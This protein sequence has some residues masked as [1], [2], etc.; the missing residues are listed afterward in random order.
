MRKVISKLLLLA[1]FAGICHAQAP[2]RPNAPP[3]RPQQQPQPGRPNVVPNAPTRQQAPITR[4]PNAP[5][6]AVPPNNRPQPNRPL[7]NPQQPQQGPV[8]PNTPTRS[9]SVPNRPPAQQP[10]AANAPRP[11][12]QPQP[13]PPQQSPGVNAPR[14]T[15]GP[16]PNQPNQP[17]QTTGAPRPPGP[18]GPTTQ[19]PITTTRRVIIPEHPENPD[20]DA[21]MFPTAPTIAPTPEVIFV[22]TPRFPNNVPIHPNIPI[23]PWNPRNEGR[24]DN[25]CPLNQNANNPIHLPHE[26]DCNRFY[27]CDHGLIFE[28]RC[29]NGQHW[30][31]R[32]N[33]CDFPN[34]ANC[35]P[36]S[37]NINNN[38]PVV[39]PS[40]QV[41]DWNTNWV[42]NWNMPN[43]NNNIVPWTPPPAVNPNPGFEN[44]III[45]MAPRT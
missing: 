15:A 20:F 29:P 10:P 39:P 35:Q 31:A 26:S 16:I 2:A 41:P 19:A 14:P 5:T 24:P 21:A 7:P 9:P 34:T 4:A 42:N 27:K 43:N 17:Q 12:A 44:P 13:Q 11:T 6:R 45:P 25:R 3:A 22:T 23:V 36:G 1:L 28:Y 30:N 37:Q 33:Y 8:R 18:P 40:P 38:V 32:R